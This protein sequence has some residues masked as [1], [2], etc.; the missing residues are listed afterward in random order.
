MKPC[1]KFKL[2][3]GHAFPSVGEVLKAIMRGSGL[4]EF[5][6]DKNT[7]KRKLRRFTTEQEI[8][9]HEDIQ[10]VVD[11]ALADILSHEFYYES[12]Q[13]LVLHFLAYYQRQVE[14][15][16]TCFGREESLRWLFSNRALGSVILLIKGVEMSHMDSHMEY[17]RLY[18]PDWACWYLPEYSDGEW[19]M[20]TQ[21]VFQWWLGLVGLRDP[22]FAVDG[23]GKRDYYPLFR[24]VSESTMLNWL[25]P[26]LHSEKPDIATLKEIEK[27][28]LDVD[29]EKAKKRSLIVTML[30]CNQVTSLTRLMVSSCGAE[31]TAQAYTDFRSLAAAFDS[32]EA[33]YFRECIRQ[34]VPLHRSHESYRDA[35]QEKQLQQDRTVMVG[36]AGEDIRKFRTIIAKFSIESMKSGQLILPTRD[37]FMAAAVKD[38]WLK[39]TQWRKQVV[40][41]RDILHAALEG[42]RLLGETKPFVGA[43]PS[44]TVREELLKYEASLSSRALEYLP[45]LIRARIEYTEGDLESA[46]SSYQLAFNYSRYCAGKRVLGIAE[47]YLSLLIYAYSNKGRRTGSNA[48]LPTIK[49]MK[50]WFRL[51]DLDHPFAGMDED[52]VQTAAKALYAKYFEDIPLKI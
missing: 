27:A 5:L 41:E 52:A 24:K 18:F 14:F 1:E 16:A 51:T 47:E 46:L 17:E 11:E 48:N 28:E 42:Q 23:D 15:E 8:L 2:P 33:V 10:A 34:C 31:A 4:W 25:K 13:H 40:A 38:D 29:D 39:E 36:M 43:L 12:A 6:K 3:D 35:T 22:K 20:P 7:L 50:K 21:R 45:H 49:Y 44:T 37:G 19:V 9:Q 26:G 30:I 32:K